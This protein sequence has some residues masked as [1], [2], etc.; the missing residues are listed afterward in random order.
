MCSAIG[1]SFDPTVRAYTFFT[2]CW[3]QE[4]EWEREQNMIKRR[5][6]ERKKIVF[7]T[8]C[9]HQEREWEREQK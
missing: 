9:R 7:L 2:L 8:L 3:R 6:Q 4:Q 5:F 1:T